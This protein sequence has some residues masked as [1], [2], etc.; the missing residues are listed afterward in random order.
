M[1]H[2]EL[3]LL[4]GSNPDCSCPI[5]DGA[6][7]FAVVVVYEVGQ[8]AR[9]QSTAEILQYELSGEDQQCLQVIIQPNDSI[10][11]NCHT[12]CWMS[13]QIAV[14]KLD[15][16]FSALF[17]NRTENLRL[18]NLSEPIKFVG[19][20]Q[21][22][23]GRIFVM[24]NTNHRG[25]YFFK[26]SFICAHGP[27]EIALRQFPDHGL[28]SIAT[29][30]SF[31]RVGRE[32][33]VYMTIPLV[34]RRLRSIL[35]CVPALNSTLFFQSGSEIM[36]KYLAPGQCMLINLWSVIAFDDSCPVKLLNVSQI[37]YNFVGADGVMLRIEGPG[38]VYFSSHGHVTRNSQEM[39]PLQ[40]TNLLSYPVAVCFRFLIYLLLLYLLLFLIGCFID[41]EVLDELK[42]QLDQLE[43][44]NNNRQEAQ[45]GGE[46]QEL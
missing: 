27:S 34:H 15:T 6:G 40:S 19:L 14:E 39:V 17:G 1:L 4:F 28:P 20:A 36:T 32:R 7:L 21:K 23:S 46:G 5:S 22:Q 30:A 45:P 33:N 41:E 11:V 26:E 43:G 25:L 29:R 12:I 44:V 35:H 38:H 8:M 3:S 24:K 2:L 37:S 18:S 13:D 9:T 42:R 16:F 31:L 10:I